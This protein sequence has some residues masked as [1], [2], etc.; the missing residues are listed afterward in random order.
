[1][2]GG[3]VLGALAVVAIAIAVSSGGGGKGLQSGTKA[4]QTQTQ[5]SSLLSGIPQS[6]AVLGNPNAKVTMDYYGDLECPTCRAFTLNSGWP[7]LVAGEVRQGKVK[8][9]FRALQSATPDVQTFQTQQVAALAAGKQNKFWNF[10]ELF[11]HEQGAEGT[12]YVNESYL[13]SLA[14]QAGVNLSTWKS[15]RNNPALLAQVQSDASAATAAGASGTPTLIFQG[16]K[17]KASPSIA[18]PSYSDLQKAISQ[19]S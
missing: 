7:Q 12:S 18:V 3:I 19:V 15:D 4:S 1:M 2:I 11:Y 9:V 10:M 14:T 13:T 8:V 16:P 5:V 17:G 6:G